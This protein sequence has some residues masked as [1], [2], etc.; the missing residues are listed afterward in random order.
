MP[1][2]RIYQRDRILAAAPLCH[3]YGMEHGLLAPVW[4]GSCA[5]LYDTFDVPAV[6]QALDVR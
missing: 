1:S 3:S 4:A 5:H 2:R 6:M